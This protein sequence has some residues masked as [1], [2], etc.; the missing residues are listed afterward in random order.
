MV[1]WIHSGTFRTGG[2]SCG[3]CILLVSLHVLTRRGVGLCR[4]WDGLGLGVFRCRVFSL[5]F[6]LPSFFCRFP[7][8]VTKYSVVVGL[9]RVVFALVDVVYWVLTRAECGSLTWLTPSII[10]DSGQDGFCRFFLLSTAPVWHLSPSSKQTGHRKENRK[11][12]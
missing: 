10:V 11:G 9:A 4:A 3:C 7:G 6:F 8:V 12:G 2:S 5:S 1:Y